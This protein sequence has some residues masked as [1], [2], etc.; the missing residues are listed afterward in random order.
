MLFCLCQKTAHP[1]YVSNGW[2]LPVV[3]LEIVLR[4]VRGWHPVTIGLS[5]DMKD[6]SG[7]DLN[8]S[9]DELQPEIERTFLCKIVNDVKIPNVAVR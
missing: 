3:H 5:L 2:I 9:C 1:L 7:N 6:I 8:F 4:D